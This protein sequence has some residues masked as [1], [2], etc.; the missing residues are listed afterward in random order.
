MISAPCTGTVVERDGRAGG[1]GDKA[2]LRDFDGWDLRGY[3][4]EAVAITS[5]QRP[6]GYD[7][8]RLIKITMIQ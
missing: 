2:W 4:Y 5:R 6:L 1:D 3:C 7:K 8:Q